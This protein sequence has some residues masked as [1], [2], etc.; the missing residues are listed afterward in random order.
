MGVDVGGASTPFLFDF[1]DDGDLDLV[2]GSQ[3]GDIKYY[4]NVGSASAPASTS[5]G[6]PWPSQTTS[7]S[8]AALATVFD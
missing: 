1:D 3:M 4:Q 2:S 8:T 7:R 5:G 6:V